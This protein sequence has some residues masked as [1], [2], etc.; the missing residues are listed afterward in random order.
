MSLPPG[1]QASPGGERE[2]AAEQLSLLRAALE[3][4]ANGIVITD[5]H[6]AIVWCNRA[7]CQLSGYPR[8]EVL[9]RNPRFQKSGHHPAAFYR[10]LWQTILV[11][12]VWQGEMINR[13]KDG[14]EYPEE[15]TITPVRDGGGRITHFIAVKQDISDRRRLESQLRQAQKMDAL[16]QLA[17]GVAH[18]FNN[19]MTVV[20]GYLDLLS[21]HTAADPESAELIREV[22]GAAERAGNLTRQLLAFG[23]R[24]PMQAQPVDLAALVD[25]LVKMLRRL[26]GENILLEL[27]HGTALPALQADPALLEQAL[28]NLAVNARDAMPN[29]GRLT[30]TTAAVTVETAHALQHPAARPGHFLRVTVQDTGHGIAPEVLP[31]IFDPFFTTKP[32]GSSAG[33]GL[34]TVHGIVQQHRGWIEVESRQGSGTTFR[35]YLPARPNPVAPASTTPIKPLPRRGSG[36]VLVVEDEGPVRELARLILEQFGYQVLEATTGQQA[37]DAWGAHPGPIDLLL[38]DVVL[39]GDLD[40]RALAKRLRTDRPG[41]PV[42]LTSGYSTTLVTKDLRPE[43]GIRLLQKPF[44]PTMLLQTVQECLD[45][46]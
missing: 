27:H 7:Y 35:L 13:R 24:Q 14:S 39:P 11:G 29:G 6:G 3:A 41:L 1:P 31:R 34:A 22:A 16:G 8:Q 18:D 23:S 32:S 4:S 37:L 21:A 15:Q 10:G 38:A 36:T 44:T 45:A 20:R 5:R 12:Q 42:I 30:V 33:L 46:Q 17:G 25:N 26:I 9:G 28:L 19:I 43:E 2:D 40:G